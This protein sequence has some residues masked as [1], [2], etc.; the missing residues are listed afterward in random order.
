LMHAI[1]CLIQSNIKLLPCKMMYALA[2]RLLRRVVLCDI[3]NDL[4]L[5]IIWHSIMLWHLV[6]FDILYALI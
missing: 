5:R 2:Y 1:L 3:T 4:A 6:R